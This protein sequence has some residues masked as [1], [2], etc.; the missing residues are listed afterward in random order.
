MII[1]FSQFGDKRMRGTWM[2]EQALTGSHTKTAALGRRED[3]RVS[4]VSAIKFFDGATQQAKLGRNPIAAV[5]GG[6]A[7][8]QDCQR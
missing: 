3:A 1:F 4:N 6:A 8:V 5:P 7:L 2:P